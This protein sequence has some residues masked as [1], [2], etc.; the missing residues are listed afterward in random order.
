MNKLPRTAFKIGHIP[1]SKGK[2]TGLHHAKQFKKGCVP[3]NKGITGSKSHM[4]GRKHS[5]GKQAWNK[6]IHQWETKKHPMFGKHHTEESKQKMRGK[7]IMATGENNHKWKG[8]VSYKYDRNVRN[9]IEFKEWRD[10]VFKRDDWCCQLCDKKHT[11]VHPHHL[12]SFTNYPKIRF[13]ENNGVT[14]CKD[15]HYLIHADKELQE[16]GWYMKGGELQFQPIYN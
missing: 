3:W 15:C 11:N 14:V 6:G 2:K 7:R 13:N 16:L 4:Y 1:W 10:I 8:G 5:L 9:S 12:F